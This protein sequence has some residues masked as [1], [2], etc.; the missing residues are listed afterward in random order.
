MSDYKINKG[1]FFGSKTYLIQSKILSFVF[2]VKF[3]FL[4][5]VLNV[6]SL[7]LWSQIHTKINYAYLIPCPIQDGRNK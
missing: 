4:V 7:G 2:F 5:L 3:D 1:I 6:L